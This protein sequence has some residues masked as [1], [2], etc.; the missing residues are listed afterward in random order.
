MPWLV[1]VHSRPGE[2][3]VDVARSS[4]G[5]C[6]RATTMIA[7]LTA[8]CLLLPCVLG[9]SLLGD[10]VWRTFAPNALLGA[11]TPLPLTTAQAQQEGWYQIATSCV[12]GLGIQVRLY[13][14]WL[15]Y[16]LQHFA[17]TLL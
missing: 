6:L 1:P 4:L 8:L 2:G 3:V 16:S 17:S 10:G 7:R 13:N 15:Y 12:P 11:A 14:D 5:L 9:S